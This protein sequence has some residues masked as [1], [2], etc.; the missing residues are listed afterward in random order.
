MTPWDLTQHSYNTKRV[1]CVTM[2]IRKP[3]YPRPSRRDQ[4]QG[5]CHRSLQARWVV[6]IETVHLLWRNHMQSRPQ[7]H[8]RWPVSLNEINVKINQLCPSDIMWR[9]CSS[10]AEVLAYCLTVP[11][12]TW[13]NVDFSLVK[14]YGIHHLGMLLTHWGRLTHICVSKLTIIGSDNGL[15]PGRRQAIIWTNGGILSIR[16]LGTNFTEILSETYTFSFK[17]IH[18]KMSSGKWRPFCLGLKKVQLVRR[19]CM[20]TI[21]WCV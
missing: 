2:D 1:L 8:M 14:F 16:N 15:S 11:S 21:H 12:L 9:H 20:P 5:Q 17:K 3:F 13:T 18:L 6:A 7:N 4:C 10:S 19:A